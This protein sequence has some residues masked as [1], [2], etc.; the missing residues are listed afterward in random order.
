MFLA[1][2]LLSLQAKKLRSFQKKSKLL[3]GN[4]KFRKPVIDPKTS[5]ERKL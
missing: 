5:P 4:K 2:F 3:G 1:S